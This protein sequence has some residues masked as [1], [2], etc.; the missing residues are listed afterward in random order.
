MSITLMRRV[1]AGL[2]VCSATTSLAFAGG[3][4]ILDRPVLP[5]FATLQAAVDHALDGETLLVAQGT[6][7]GCSIDGKSLALIAA[8]NVSVAIE[9]TLEVSSL[10][11]GGWVVLAGLD[12]T[13][14][15][16]PAPQQSDPALRLIS[17]LGNVRAQKCEFNGGAGALSNSGSW[18]YHGAGGYGAIVIE[19]SRVAFSDCTLVGGNGGSQSSGNYESTGGAGGRGLDAQGSRVVLYDSVLRGGRGGAGGSEGGDGGDACRALG[20]HTI[21]S[22][23]SFTGGSGGNAWDFLPYQAGDGGNGVYADGNAQVRLLDCDTTGGAGGICYSCPTNGANGAGSTGPGSVAIVAGVARALFAATTASERS[24]W[25][26]T[27]TGVPGDVVRIA[28]SSAPS[29]GIP[30][31]PAGALLVP[32]GSPELRSI[33]AVIPASGVLV[34]PVRVGRIAEPDAGR[35]QFLQ[36]LITDSS[37]TAWYGSPLHRFTF[38][39]EGESDCNANNLLDVLEVIEGASPDVDHNLVPDACDS[40]CNGNGVLDGLD[41]ANGTSTDVNQNLVPDSCEPIRTWYVQAGA[42]PGG[43]GSASAPFMSLRQGVVASLTGDTV[44]VGDGTYTGS[45]NRE[46]AFGGRTISVRSQ[47]GAAACIVDCESLGRAFRL[48]DNEGPG[49]EIRGLTL[50]N[51]FASDTDSLAPIGG[52]AIHA[53]VGSVL[54]VVDCVI[55][56]CNTPSYGGGIRMHSGRIDGCVL[57]QNTSLGGPGSQSNG[58][59]IFCSGIAVIHACSVEDN[60]ATVGAGISAAFA[61]DIHLTIDRCRIVGN[62]A[63]AFGGGVFY[64]SGGAS[65]GLVVSNSLIANNSAAEGGGVYVLKWVGVEFNTVEL[66][67]CTLVGNSATTKGSAL[68]VGEFGDVYA[69]NSI[70][71]ANPSTSGRQAFVNG[72]AIYPVANLNVQQSDWQGGSGGV[73]LGPNGGQLIWGA[74]NIDL[75]PLFA[76]ADYRLG[77]GSPCIDSGANGLLALDAAD[78][79]GDGNVLEATPFD[80][81]GAIRRYDDPSVV[82]T[83][84]GAA[85]LCDLGCYEKQP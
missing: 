79:D 6:Y 81:D 74:G 43:D 25:S 13:G 19:S 21:A 32:S 12:V 46:V 80:L 23:A 1:R 31:P 14:A 36:G 70:V 24:L 77:A 29:F 9:G 5:P 62:T 34:I 72:S 83:G 73:T 17:N 20:L 65:N 35:F 51:G 15:T 85:P 82:D 60:T 61:S 50:R 30:N 53:A 45:S 4:R 16:R 2:F 84:V 57:R 10:P 68:F 63:E 44:L 42:A 18:W 3:V 55:E 71:R 37:G 7:A 49:A 27:A 47:N 78:A 40:D 28:Y 59:A 56:G 66:R 67:N 41:I 22:G 69:L 26:V 48:V 76:G 75:D 64:R 54:T 58:G 11:L 8:P 52:G 39:R 33:A 38:D